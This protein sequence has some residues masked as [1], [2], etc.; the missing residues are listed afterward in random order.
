MRQSVYDKGK[1]S[2]ERVLDAAIATLAKKGYADTSVQDIADA[3]RMSK[4]AVHYHFESKDELYERVLARCCEVLANR[5]HR[6]LEEPGTPMDRVRRAMVEM[7]AAR[8]DGAPEV[9]VLSELFIMARQNPTT[10]RAL[11]AALRDSRKQ[12]V[13]IGFARLLELGLRPKMPLDVAARL[14]LATL[15]GL[16]LHHGVDPIGPEEEVELLQAIETS[17]MAVFAL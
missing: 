11:A 6:V 8:R 13:E 14:L 17:M 9:R 3:A 2:Q 5:I 1:G 4:G 7:W 12:I 15:D 10:R 16:A